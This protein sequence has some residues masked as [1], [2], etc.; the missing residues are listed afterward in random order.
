MPLTNGTWSGSG[1]CYF[2]HWLSRLQQKTIFPEFFCVLRY[3]LKVPLH[4]FSK[5][6]G[7]VTKLLESR[8]FLLFLLDDRKIR[9]RILIW[10]CTSDWWIRIRIQ[11]VQKHTVGMDP[12]LQHWVL[13]VVL[14]PWS[15]VLKI[16]PGGWRSNTGVQGK[17]KKNLQKNK[18]QRKQMYKCDLKDP[19]K[20]KLIETDH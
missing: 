14:S 15:T 4:H 3:L 16:Y 1:S 12:D 7:Y 9:S 13:V 11:E 19:F 6:K 8:F 5:K 10:I 20:K 17:I 18:W 2:R